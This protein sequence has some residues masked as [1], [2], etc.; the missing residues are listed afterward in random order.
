[1][2]A[3]GNLFLISG[4]MALQVGIPEANI[5]AHVIPKEKS[6]KVAELQK[7]GHITCFVGDGVNDSPALAQSDVG[8][9]LGAGTGMDLSFD[10]YS[11]DSPLE[12]DL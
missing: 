11:G 9:A 4:D 3:R 8:I 2:T 6:E 10:L 5:F 1:M 7:V 12:H